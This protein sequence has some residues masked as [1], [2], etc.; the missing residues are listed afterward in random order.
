MDSGVQV[1]EALAAE[2]SADSAAAVILAA[3]ARV[4][5]G[6]RIYRRDIR[7]KGPVGKTLSV[8]S[9]SPWWIVFLSSTRSSLS[10]TE[11]SDFPTDSFR[12]AVLDLSESSWMSVITG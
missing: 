6:K 4:A 10:F 11:K 8:C 12:S 2:A 5:V 3:A 1:E 7:V 9:V